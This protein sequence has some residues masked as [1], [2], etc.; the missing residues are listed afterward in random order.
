MNNRKKKRDYDWKA[1]KRNIPNLVMYT[2]IMRLAY[3]FSAINCFLCVNVDKSA[4]MG[5]IG[6]IGVGI[7]NPSREEKDM[8]GLGYTICTILVWMFNAVFAYFFS[9]QQ[10]TILY[11]IGIEIVLFVVC[12][13]IT[14]NK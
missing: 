5:V 13:Q 8:R 7:V 11:A 4:I 14:K 2:W 12:V 3:F 6:F 10:T 9:Q 1:N